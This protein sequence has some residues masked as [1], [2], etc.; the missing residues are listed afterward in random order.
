MVRDKSQSIDVAPRSGNSSPVMGRKD[1]FR[2][3]HLAEPSRTGGAATRKR[4]PSGAQAAGIKFDITPSD[5]PTLPKQIN[6][7]PAIVGPAP[8]RP[9][10]REKCSCPTC[11][12]KAWAAPDTAIVC[13]ICSVPMMDGSQEADA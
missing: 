13:G 7:K 2:V 9:N 10:T 12:V 8:K 1:S 3:A 11:G 4:P 5:S 6:G